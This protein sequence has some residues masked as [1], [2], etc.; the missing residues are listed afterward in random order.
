L[1]DDE[2]DRYLAVEIAKTLFAAGAKLGPYDR[3]ICS[4]QSPTAT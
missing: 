2:I 1:S 3:D 4:T